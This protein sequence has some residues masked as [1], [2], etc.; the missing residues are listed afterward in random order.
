MLCANHSYNAS[1]TQP[2]DLC[3]LVFEFRSTTLFALWQAM[4]FPI[5]ILMAITFLRRKDKNDAKWF[6][7]HIAILNLIVIIL[8]ELVYIFPHINMSPV[9]WFLLSLS[10]DLAQNSI[11]PL[12]ITRFLI[13]YFQGFYNKFF[14][15]KTLLFWM[16]LYDFV[17][18]SL[19]SIYY[20]SASKTLFMLIIYLIIL[21]G[22]FLC[23]ILVFI[24]INNMRKLAKS[25]SDFPLS[26]INRA[27]FICIFQATI[28]LL[29]LSSVFFTR[30]YSLFFWPQGISDEGN[31]SY[32]IYMILYISNLTLYQFSVI[33]YTVTTLLILKSYRNSLIRACSYLFNV[34]TWR[35][36]SDF[37][38]N[39]RV[40]KVSPPV[41]SRMT[42]GQI[43]IIKP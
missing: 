23:T 17:L 7:F 24:K 4:L 18:S 41:H 40:V 22:S 42:S 8:W 27:A 38:I 43:K 14:T 15:K 10:E 25:S 37:S 28:N 35:N 3:D 29:L 32:S 33:L 2:R 39:P 5:L 34:Q 20:F 12:A 21:L 36:I 16:L 30:I 19:F 11:F 31:I 13:M 6:V 1:S 26:D 9:M